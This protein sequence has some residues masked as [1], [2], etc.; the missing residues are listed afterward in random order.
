MIRNW[1]NQI[2]YPALKTKREINKYTKWQQFTKV[3]LK[4][5]SQIARGDSKKVFIERATS[6]E[7]PDIETL[8]LNLIHLNIFPLSRVSLIWVRLL[9][10][11][12]KKKKK[13]KKNEYRIH[14][15]WVIFVI[16]KYKHTFLIWIPY[17]SIKQTGV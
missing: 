5:F 3:G 1:Y 15:L 13:K 2:P 4:T 6:T 10:F 11:A 9:E 7:D 8:L 16:A 12:K 17:I 14:R